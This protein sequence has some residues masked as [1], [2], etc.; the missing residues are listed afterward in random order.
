MIWGI[1]MKIKNLFHAFQHANVNDEDIFAQNEWIEPEPIENVLLEVSPLPFNNIPAPF[2][3]WVADVAERMQC[4]P[5]FIAVAAIVTTASLIGSGC[6]V[7]PKQQDDWLV[8]PNVWGGLIGRPGM[9]KTPAVAEVMQLIRPLEAAAKKAYDADL[10]RY[11]A[12]LEVYKADK[13]AIKSALIKIR[14]Q[15]LQGKSESNSFETD[16]LRE[17][18]LS[19]K[20]PLKPVW[21]RYKSNDPTVEKITELLAENPRGLLLYRDELVGL[22]SSWEREGREGDRAF[23][24]EAWNGDGSMTVDRIG[25]G[26]IHVKNLCISIF[27]NTQP[28]KI[29]SYLHQAMRGKDNDGLLQRFQL[30][31][32]PDEPKEWTLVDRAPDLYARQRVID[33][34]NK[35]ASMNFVEHGAI[36]DVNDRFPF[37]HFDNDAQYVF[38]DWLTKLEK[39]RSESKDHPVLLEHLAKYRSLF[40][41][42]ALIFHLIEL[43]DGK[44]RNTISLD[45][46]VM[47]LGWCG[48]LERHARRIY[49]MANNNVHHAVVKL[50]KKIKEGEL[51]S[52]FTVRD[53]YRREWSMLTERKIVQKACDELVAAGWIRLELQAYQLGRPKLPMYVINPKLRIHSA[54]EENIF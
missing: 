49:G 25:R 33:I 45:A 34:I 3:D 38:N 27:G 21:K 37:F 32:Y 42:L 41:S 46:V 19:S 13:E 2:R 10:A 20:E 31:I 24:L 15:G 39:Y 54:T 7:K 36:L 22:L 9:L 11:L 14:K 40:P 35:I 53:I 52:P 43:A 30:L 26:T 12:D 51:S 28:A 17:E 29:M 6:G 44:Q 16:V 23:F 5:D 48:Y 18:L 4:P 47:A 50:A 8:I 1:N